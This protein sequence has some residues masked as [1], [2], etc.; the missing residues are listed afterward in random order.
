VGNVL[1]KAW[2]GELQPG[3]AGAAAIAAACVLAALAVRL[4]SNAFLGVGHLPGAPFFPAVLLATL[5]GGPVTGLTAAGASVIIIW[6][7][8]TPPAFQW[9]LGSP[10]EAADLT[11]YTATMLLIVW[12]G[13]HYRRLKA[14]ADALVRETEAHAKRLALALDAGGMGTWEWNMKTGAVIWSPTLEA[15]HGL[16]PGSFGGTFEEFRKDI[17]PDDRERVLATIAESVAK[18]HE[19]RVEYRI[20]PPDGRVRW[21]EARGNVVRFERGKPATMI[22]ICADITERKRGEEK[23]QL[24]AQELEHRTR[25]ILATVKAIMRLTRADSVPDF[26]T[27]VGNRL[28]A[29]ARTHKLLSS[30]RWQGAELKRLIGEELSPYAAGREKRVDILGPDLLLSV[31]GAE[32]FGVVIHELTTNAVKYGALSR[33]G[34]RLTVQWSQPMRNQVHFDWIERGARM[35]TAPTHIGFGTRVIRTIIEREL[36]GKVEF[37]WQSDGLH[38]HMAVPSER[39]RNEV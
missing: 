28:D 36:S 20:L 39:L 11:I 1:K 37:G 3:P 19:H 30:N 2:R 23:V 22:G 10:G 38:C 34:G 13:D 25:N 17:H 14:R 24:F 26:V 8:L 33:P 35:N 4:V 29:L 5:F 16:P 31:A 9:I 21:L 7:Y 27:A 15:I 12:A 32:S 18:R 6:W